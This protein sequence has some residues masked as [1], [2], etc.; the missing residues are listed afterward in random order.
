MTQF[1]MIK[2]EKKLF[3]RDVFGARH[4]RRLMWQRDKEVERQ[5]G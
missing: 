4:A 5:G 3:E 2:E 1:T